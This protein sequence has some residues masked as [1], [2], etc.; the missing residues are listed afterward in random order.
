MFFILSKTLDY[1]VM[2]TTVILLFLLLG[3]VVRK[4]RWRK[5]IRVAGLVLLFLFTNDFIANELMRAWEIDT[6]PYSAMEPYPV[7]IVLTG[8]MVGDR[9]PDDRVYFSRGA[10]RVVHTV[11][12][13]KRGLIQKILI[14]GG[15]G[16]ISGESRPEADR[17]RDAMLLMGVPDSVIML[18]NRAQNTA[19]SAL[20]VPPMIEEMGYT[21]TDCLLI[22][23]AFHM[24]R[25]LACFRKAGFHPTP[26]TVDFYAGS[27]KRYNLKTFLLPQLD[28]LILWHKLV[29]EWVGMVAY[30]VVGYV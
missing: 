8:V 13:Y 11:Q 6:Q 30:W 9:E 20:L 15:S 22:T 5:W 16:L 7:G 27:R 12:L 14:S 29:K 26:F 19:Q 1:L 18:E 17:F 10:D 25:S 23:S 2:P 3:I 4:G 24:R 21:D 28:A